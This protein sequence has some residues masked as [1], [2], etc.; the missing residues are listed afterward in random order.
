LVELY[1]VLQSSERDRLTKDTK[2]G[3]STETKERDKGLGWIFILFFESER[4]Q[5]DRWSWTLQERSMGSTD[6]IQGRR[7]CG[8]C[9]KDE[10]RPRG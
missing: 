10:Q 2:E 1:T 3:S 4:Y 8:P 6:T 9:D 5:I 7:T